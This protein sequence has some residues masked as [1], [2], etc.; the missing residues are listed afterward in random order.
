MAIVKQDEYA[1]TG[2][3][4][5]QIAAQTAAQV[6]KV[7]LPT[8]G[9]DAA[10]KTML[11]LAP[12]VPTP[13]STVTSPSNVPVI[14]TKDAATAAALPGNTAQPSVFAFATPSAEEGGGKVWNATTNTWDAKPIV[15]APSTTTATPPPYNPNIDEASNR[16]AFD[17]FYAQQPT[18]QTGTQP[19]NPYNP[20]ID[21]TANKDAFNAFY[22]EKPAVYTPPDKTTVV[23]PSGGGT[24]GG[25]GG[26]ATGTTTT[27]LN[28]LTGQATT[29]GG[30]PA[31]DTINKST[32]MLNDI[33][34][35]QK[36]EEN[37]Y[38]DKL[39]AMKFEYNPA[40]DPDY[41]NDSAK[42]EQQVTNMMVSRGGLYSSVAQSALQSRLTDLMGT[43]RKQAYE[44]FKED[45]NYTLQM[46][47]MVYDRQDKDFS[48][49]LSLYSAQKDSEDT[50][51]DQNQ[52]LAEFQFSVK[53]SEFNNQLNLAKFNADR[54]D[55]ANSLAI[56]RANLKL[57]QEN[58][59]YNKE[60]QNAKL[61][62]A[63]QSNTLLMMQGNY[64]Q[65]SAEYSRLVY[66]WVKDTYAD[67]EVAA[68]FGS[69]VQYLPFDSSGAINAMNQGKVALAQQEQQ[70]A[71]YAKQTND[72]SLYLD[73]LDSLQKQSSDPATTERQYATN[74]NAL[75]NSA[76]SAY[77][78][79]NKTTKLPTTWK[80]L[81]TIYSSDPALLDEVGTT[82]YNKFMSDLQ[83]KV[84]KEIS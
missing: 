1:G 11:D 27:Q 39:N 48:K 83:E 26:T 23:K 53:Q 49:A 40:T 41:R 7:P 31:T 56:Q 45:R 59:A 77:G 25:S 66:K 63:Q 73:T 37:Q 20:N 12:V 16:A 13:K 15:Q 2:L 57:S 17:A 54:Q 60:I 35:S 18:T 61:V 34:G 58:S 3:T 62:Q 8:G 52:K 72:G 82:Y 68:Y 81:Y 74:Y 71:A 47:Q 21:E 38:I 36:D 10:R 22:A 6:V 19:V 67:A 78:A 75:V 70:I 51:W 69:N 32:Q 76:Y 14:Q 44:I 65:D 46:A 84:T 29:G 33:I 79:V 43:Y 50:S 30:Q 24:S 28:P 42:L 55:Q 5:A 64:A 9:K 4:A 80:D